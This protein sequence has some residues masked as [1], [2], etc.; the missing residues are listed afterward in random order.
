MSQKYYFYLKKYILFIKVT[1][2]MIIIT[3]IGRCSI[4]IYKVY[5]CMYIQRMYIENFWYLQFL[6]TDKKE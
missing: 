4:F 5:V 6:Y 1:I 2:L 3:S